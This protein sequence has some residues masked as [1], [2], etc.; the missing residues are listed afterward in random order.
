M[1]RAC[2]PKWRFG[3]QAWVP[4]RAWGIILIQPS[5][6][7]LRHFNKGPPPGG[8]LGLKKK[9]YSVIELLVYW[10]KDLNIGGTKG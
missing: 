1:V 5:A 3:T 4:L 6:F 7:Y 9:V 8:V 10:V 2:T